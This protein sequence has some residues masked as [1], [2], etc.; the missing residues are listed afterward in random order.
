MASRK[1]IL[2]FEVN[3]KE[4]SIKYSGKFRPDW[5]NLSSRDRK[6]ELRHFGRLC[7]ALIACPEALELLSGIVHAV[8]RYKKREAKKCTRKRNEN[9]SI[10]E[11]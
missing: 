2:F 3:D 1:T 4:Y 6:A 9:G 5:D 10:T 8:E 7:D 11:R